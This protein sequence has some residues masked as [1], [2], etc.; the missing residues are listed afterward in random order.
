MF[1]FEIEYKRR[2]K[3]GTFVLYLFLPNGEIEL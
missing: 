2:T 3:A 1:C